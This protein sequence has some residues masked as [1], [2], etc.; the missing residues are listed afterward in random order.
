MWGD[1]TWEEMA[2]AF[3]E[4]AT[5]LASKD[6]EPATRKGRNKESLAKSDSLGTGS[7]ALD[8]ANE[9]M[10]RF[11]KNGD[12]RVA[13]SETNDL[14]RRYS[15]NTIDKNGDGFLDSDELVK[16]FEGRRGR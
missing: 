14:I 7:A 8:W 2:V 5:P 9:Y 13:L 3:F 11:D 4:I 12:G 1:Q 16:S 15:F 6:S 10:G